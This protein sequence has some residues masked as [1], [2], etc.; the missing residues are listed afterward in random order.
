MDGQDMVAQT[1]EVTVRDNAESGCY[2]AL[3]G[4]DVVGTIVY[5]YHGPRMVFMHTIVEPDFRRRGIATTLAKAALDDVRA[6][7]L[8]LSNYCGFVAEFIEAN[9]EYAD[10]IDAQ[11]PGHPRRR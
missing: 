7:G 3:I 8:K 9:P 6:R 11:H 10:L 1:P 5:E 4:G 2:E